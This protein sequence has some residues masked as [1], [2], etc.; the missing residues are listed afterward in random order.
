MSSSVVCFM[1]QNSAVVENKGVING[2][3][4]FLNDTCMGETSD[5]IQPGYEANVDCI[6]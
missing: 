3:R 6:C 4:V 2:P 1:S 5:K